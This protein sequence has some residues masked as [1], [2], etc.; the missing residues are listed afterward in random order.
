MMPYYI[1]KT[2]KACANKWAVI[3]S[4]RVIHGCHA[5]KT[6]AIAQMVAISI[7][8]KMT[9]GG[10]WPADKKKKQ[11]SYFFQEAADGGY[12]P[13]AGVQSAAKRALK[14]IADGKAGGGFTS[15]GRRRAAQLASGVSVSRDTVARMKSYFAR[16]TVD[17]KATGFSAGEKGYPSAGRVAWDAWGG[18]AGKAWVN[19]INLDGKK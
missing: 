9:P 2:Q 4:D 10:T 6:A 16:H 8:Q 12:K 7:A 11:E 17:K 13:P 18:D 5:T 19:R 15:V 3:S 1:S 14:W